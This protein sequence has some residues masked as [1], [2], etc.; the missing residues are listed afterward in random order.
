MSTLDRSAVLTM[1]YRVIDALNLQRTKTRKLEKSPE[2]L[3]VGPGSSLDSLM[4]MNLIVETES[5][6]LD[7]FG[8]EVSLAD[9]IGLPQDQNPFRTLGALADYLAMGASDGA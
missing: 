9:L 1:L 7:D 6:L 5:R 3:L 2:L 8:L 4:L